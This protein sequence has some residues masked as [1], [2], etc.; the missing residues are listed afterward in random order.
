MDIAGSFFFFH[1]ILFF[2]CL[3]VLFWKSN[4]AKPYGDHIR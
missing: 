3:F 1:F 4:V 2:V